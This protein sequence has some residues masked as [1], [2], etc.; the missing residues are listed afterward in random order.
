MARKN[1]VEFYVN[2]E[3]TVKV[4]FPNGELKCSNCW[5][6]VTRAMNRDQKYCF[7]ED[8]LVTYSDNEI[9]PWCPL[10]FKEEDDELT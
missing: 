10:R 8:M 2:G 5:F 4:G 9:A 1:T 6:C 7:L 3:T